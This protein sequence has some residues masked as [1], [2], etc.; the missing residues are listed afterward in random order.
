MDCRKIV[1]KGSESDVIAELCSLIEKK[2]KV[3]HLK[4]L[5]RKE[6]SYIIKG[7]IMR[8]FGRAGG[9]PLKSC[10]IWLKIDM[11]TPYNI[12]YSQIIFWRRTTL[13]RPT[14]SHLKNP[15]LST[16]IQNIRLNF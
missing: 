12:F 11:V 15:P 6:F 3:G 16:L 14:S 9:R 7:E 10:P 8:V 13:G 5:I 2:A 4:L 1:V